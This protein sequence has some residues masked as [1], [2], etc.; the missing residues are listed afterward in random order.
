MCF[1]LSIYFAQGVAVSM[2][3]GS[4]SDNALVLDDLS[5]ESY[6]WPCVRLDPSALDALP[7]SNVILAV[8]HY[9]RR[10]QSAEHR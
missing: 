5:H 4:G 7:F 3:K 2:S 6:F 10:R 9:P 8:V 1:V